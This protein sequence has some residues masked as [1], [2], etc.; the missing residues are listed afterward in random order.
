MLSCSTGKPSRYTN[1]F[2]RLCVRFQFYD[3]ETGIKAQELGL[4]AVPVATD[5][6]AVNATFGYPLTVRKSCLYV[7]SSQQ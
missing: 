1:V 5:P 7:L 3:L 6:R 4:V 2:D